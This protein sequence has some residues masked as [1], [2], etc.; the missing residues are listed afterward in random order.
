ME[1]DESLIVERINDLKMITAAEPEDLMT[2]HCLQCNTVLADSLGVCGELKRIDSIMCI[3][4]TNDVVVSDALESVRKGEMAN[5]ICSHLKCRFCNC[6]VGKVV[7]AAPL[8]LA[9]TR[10]VFLLNKAKM[11]CYILDS[12]SMV[13]ATS[14]SFDLRPLQETVKEA[15]Q[16]FEEQLDLM[17]H[18]CSRLADMSMSISSQSTN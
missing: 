17:A 4:V 10:S 16:E 2:L 15:R 13:K 14:L 3:R 11:S 18:T 6:V 9:A 8:H 5:C 7:H 12:S 1:F